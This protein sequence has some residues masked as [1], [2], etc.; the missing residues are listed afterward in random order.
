M[1]CS[2]LAECGVCSLRQRRGWKMICREG[3]VFEL[4]ELL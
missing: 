4:G 3:P 1:P 2:A